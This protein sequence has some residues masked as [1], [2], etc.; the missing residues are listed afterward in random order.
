LNDPAINQAIEYTLGIWEDQ[1]A[2]E[3]PIRVNIVF[4]PVLPGFLGRSIP[5]GR[6]NFPGAPLAEVWYPTSLAKAIQGQDINPGEFD[7]D[8]LIDGGANWY[9]GTDGNPGPNQF[10]FPTVLLHEVC[11][12]LGFGSIGGINGDL[13]AFGITSQVTGGASTSFPIPD[14]EGRPSIFD[15][16]MVNG[17]HESLVDSSLF[18]NN[19]LDLGEAFT[20]EQLFFGGNQTQSLNQ[21]TK[22]PLHAPRIYAEGSSL[23]HIKVDTY[24]PGEPNGLMEPFFDPG[25]VIHEPGPVILAVLEDLGWTIKS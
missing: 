8:I 7:M 24:I 11:H 16:F 6:K 2:T 13:G 4:L 25:E 18:S 15:V 10:D 21:N 22:L 17:S 23:S 5:N 1:L 19:S 12:S 14:L 3:V 9:F 20:S